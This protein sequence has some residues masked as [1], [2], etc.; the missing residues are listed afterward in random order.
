[1]A[2]IISMHSSKQPDANAWLAPGR[3]PSFAPNGANS[4]RDVLVKGRRPPGECVGHQAAAVAA[5]DL[6]GPPE[7]FAG[8]AGA[9]RDDSLS[10]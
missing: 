6:N 9:S 7:R 10:C 5:A 1:M 3:K 4:D 2:A 8:I